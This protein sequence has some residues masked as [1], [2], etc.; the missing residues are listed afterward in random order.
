MGTTDGDQAQP[1]ATNAAAADPAERPTEVVPKDVLPAGPAPDQSADFRT[2]LIADIRGYTSYTDERGDEAA[3]A[4]ANRFAG[5]VR[6][7]VTAREGTLVELRGDEALTVFRSARQ[8]LRAAVELQG[9]I[10]DAQLPRGIGIGLDAG[11]AVPVE[12]GY[13]GT[14]LNVAARLCAQAA[15]GEILATETVIHLAA[16]IEGIRYREPKAIRLKGFESPVRVVGVQ[17]E[18][19]PG[20]SPAVA[21]GRKSPVPTSG[22]RPAIAALVAVA[23][24]VVGGAL[25]FAQ[26]LGGRGSAAQSSPAGAAPSPGASSALA[27][28][29]AGAS[30]GP[31]ASGAVTG[32]GASPAVSPGSSPAL[33]AADVP[34]YKGALGRTNQMPGPALGATP[35]IRWTFPIGAEPGAAP[36]VA[37]NLV[38]A[39][40]SDGT[41]HVIDLATGQEA[42]SFAAGGPIAS[43][44]S[45]VNGSVYVASED[46]VLHA[47]DLASHAERWHV[48]GI[49]KGS[50]PTVD[51]DTAYVGLTTG[52]FAAL[53]VADGREA[54]HVDVDGSASRAAIADGTAYVVGDG[55]DRLYA[56]D[57]ADHTIAW[58][59]AT[60]AARSITPAV[61]GGSVYMAVVEVS[62]K[63]SRV[64]ALDAATG[65]ERWAFRAPDRQSL[66]SLAVGA[67]QVLTTSD[68][69]SGTSDVW[70]IDRTT[71]KLRWTASVPASIGIHPTLVGD[72]VDMMTTSGTVVALTAATG[73]QLWRFDGPGRAIGSPVLTGGLLIQATTTG[74][75]EALAAG[76]GQPAAVP[77]S[78]LEWVADLVTG[79]SAP[80]LFLNVMVD[81][82]GNV[83][84]ADRFGNRV[85]IWDRAGHPIVWG[86]HGSK[87]GEFDF[88]EVTL[89]DQSQSVAVAPDGRIAV[90]DGGN[91]RVQI[92]DAKRHFI[93]AIGKFGT[94]LKPGQMVNPCCVAFGPDGRLYV[95]DPGRG[96]IQVF[97]KKGRFIRIIGSQGSG[98]GQFDRLGVPFVDP[99][100]GNLWVPDF[101]NHRVEVMTA[102]GAFVTAFGDDPGEQTFNEVNGVVLDGAGRMWVVDTDDYLYVLDPSGRRIAQFGPDYPGHGTIQPAFLWLTADGRLYMPDSNHDRISVLQVRAPLWPPPGN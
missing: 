22:S 68:G 18:M 93:R 53:S 21:S 40:G 91:H 36:A 59:V 17:A 99:A 78:A 51:G 23:V 38:F 30:P 44:P 86:H 94:D 85:V 92:F 41:L 31:N 56:I 14:A 29:P 10:A 79:D 84:G 48:A 45:V 24:L 43:T 95:A 83:Y 39:G 96:D 90:G 88:G 8:A 89:G 80:T 20:G 82:K 71:G 12:G 4:L 16:R 57:L 26:G 58:S 19:V 7:A 15:A 101:S 1:D 61:D 62:G 97:D 74:G 66:V 47:V 87:P 33:P 49:S 70:A 32:P 35:A 100:T 6:E 54:W 63:D 55:S 75:I 67:D 28:S 2:F 34:M 52:R 72:E 46:G 9:R 73:Q 50:V 25:V 60:G 77:G 64:L 65:Q 37:G 81:A 102:N 5:L 76:S 27:G 11:E 3:A 42:W 98:N 13:R 69:P